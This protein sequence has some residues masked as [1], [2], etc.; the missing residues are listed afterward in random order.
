VA[1]VV[2]A[3]DEDLK[4]SVQV[5][6]DYSL[7][8]VLP[9]D[10]LLSA[11]E[12]GERVVLLAAD[13]GHVLGDGTRTL[14]GRMTR[15][16]PGGARWRALA[17]GETPAAEEVVLPKGSWVPRGFNRVAALWDPAV[18]NRSAS[19]GEHGGLSLSEAVAPA[20]LIAPDWLE[21]AVPDDSSLAVRPLPTP[22]WWELRVRRAA[23]RPASPAP[24]R[25]ERAVQESLFAPTMVEPVRPPVPAVPPFVQAL[26]RSSV[27]QSQIAGQPAA[28]IER[29]L[30]WLTI[31]I[32]AGDFLPA[33]DFAAA[34]GVRPHQVGGVVARM[35]MLNAD[36]FAMIEHDHV[37]RRVVLHRSRLV[38]HYG[39]KQ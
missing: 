18:S 37:G 14:E 22:D 35:G 19:Y 32:E 5:A 13:H 33:S 17:E 30:A 11:A 20:I 26:R 7:A 8:P 15:G 10:A 21:R 25:P 36:G 6:K 39:V 1:V 12:E 38:Q 28:E 34:A 23:P 3:I 29:V 4:S 2:N 16:R 24:M 9:L 27:F 31:L